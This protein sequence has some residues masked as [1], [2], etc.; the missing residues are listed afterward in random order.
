[1]V[2]TDSKCN[3]AFS[4]N[5]GT[6]VGN[7]CMSLFRA[8]YS[9]GWTDKET[10]ARWNNLL[11]FR[12]SA[13]INASL[14]N[15]SAVTCLVHHLTFYSQQ[16]A[17]RKRSKSSDVDKIDSKERRSET[18]KSHWKPWFKTESTVE[19][20]KVTSSNRKKRKRYCKI[21]NNVCF[22]FWEQN[23]DLLAVPSER[24]KTSSNRRH[25]KANFTGCIVTDWLSP[26]FTGLQTL[27]PCYPRVKS[28]VEVTP[29]LISM[30]TEGTSASHLFL[31]LLSFFW[32]TKTSGCG[33]MV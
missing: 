9:P 15:L 24:F 25:H 14:L 12:T 16:K 11:S 2:P 19:I 1:M 21:A 30:A 18:G 22:L 5:D 13:R 28:G 27:T 8:V 32:R 20:E 6:D 7:G 31:L 17:K 23:T 3:W 26:P 10:S 4:P 29:Y 33:F